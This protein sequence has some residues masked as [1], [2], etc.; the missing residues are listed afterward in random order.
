MIWCLCGER[1][2]DEMNFE[3]IFYHRKLTVISMSILAK[4]IFHYKQFYLFLYRSNINKEY[5]NKPFQS[6]VLAQVQFQFLYTLLTL[7]LQVIMS[8]GCK[9]LFVQLILSSLL[10]LHSQGQVVGSLI[11]FR[12]LI[13]SENYCFDSFNQIWQF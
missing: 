3:K 6:M 4:S 7:F 8:C 9:T 11:A 13:Q 10:N 1:I 12:S 2:S 5:I